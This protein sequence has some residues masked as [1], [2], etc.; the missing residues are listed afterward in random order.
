MEAEKCNV[1]LAEFRE[2][3][4]DDNGVCTQCNVM[5]PGA[6]TPEDRN[7]NKKHDVENQETITKELV[8]KKVDEILEKYGILH[9]CDCG[10]LF[11][12]RSPAQKKCGNCKGPSFAS[13][14]INKG[15]KKS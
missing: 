1:C 9:K 15:D 3:M 7:K 10:N 12:K 2:G 4:L 5:W 11:Y 13:M 8:I 14:N 6:K